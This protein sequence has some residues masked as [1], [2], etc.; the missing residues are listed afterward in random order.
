MY[1][2]AL[3]VIQLHRRFGSS[4]VIYKKLDF[5]MI[6]LS[7]RVLKVHT[8]CEERV[9]YI[10]RMPWRKLLIILLSSLPRKLRSRDWHLL[11]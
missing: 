4:C 6:K 9:R 2:L 1:H 7:I 10:N 8:F 3:Y 11:P 5:G